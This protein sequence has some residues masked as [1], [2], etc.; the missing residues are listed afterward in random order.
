MVIEY[1]DL[2]GDGPNAPIITSSSDLLANA[3]YNASMVVLNETESPVDDITL[4]I[5]DEDIAHQFFLPSGWRF[6]HYKHH[7]FRFR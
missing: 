6:E 2:D 3:S 1:R 7:L 4:E 5:K